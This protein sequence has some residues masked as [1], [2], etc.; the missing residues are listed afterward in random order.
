M[1]IEAVEDHALE[2]AEFP[3]QQ[4]RP[5]LWAACNLSGWLRLLAHNRFAVD[6]AFWPTVL[7]TTL[8]SA[9]ATAVGWVQELRFGR[10]V[11]RTKVREAPLF[12]LGHWR[13]GTT[14][15]H[16]LLSLDEQH[17]FPTTLE[18]FLPDQFLLLENWLLRR[19][20]GRH[21]QRAYDNVSLG[22]DTP[23]E[24]EFA[25]LMMGAPTP[26]LTMA[27]P[28]HPPMDPEF[29]D[30]EGVSPRAR[31]AWERQFLRFLQR[32]TF[33]RPRRLVLKSPTH[34]ARIKSLLRL[35]PD[36]R[37]VHIVRNP[38]VVF[39]S[40][41]KMQHG[42]FLSFSLQKPPY[43]NL[44]EGI[45]TT[46]LR[47]F[48]RLEE[49]KRLVDPAHFY[50]LRYEDLVRD[51]VGEIRTIYEHLGLSGFEALRPRLENYLAGLGHYQT[52]RHQLSPEL[53]AEI[54]RR[55]GTIIDRYGYGDFGSERKS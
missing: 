46:Y 51:P 16:D 34:T 20:A 8:I 5:N 41:L 50:E 44:E 3:E 22:M 33:R 36:A 48:Q 38:Y 55:W 52:N 37:F 4:H 24:D 28:K 15:L 53:H 6:R 19:F 14:Y 21:V 42:I 31:R 1:T 12:V 25:L 30:L 32:I 26:Y 10:Q 47:V 40:T 23:Q 39:P 27:F 9:V 13:S 45:F 43:E 18:C 7:R 11:A 35:F 54:T 29:L 49:G 2:L 17:T